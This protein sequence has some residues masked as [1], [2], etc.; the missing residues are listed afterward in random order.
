M[1]HGWGLPTS[2]LN[3]E[4]RPKQAYLPLQTACMPALNCLMKMPYKGLCKTGACL[5]TFLLPYWRTAG[6]LLFL[7]PVAGWGQEAEAWEEEAACLEM[8]LLRTAGLAGT[9]QDCL[10]QFFPSQ[11]AVPMGQA[12][13]NTLTCPAV[14]GGTD[15][16]S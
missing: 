12:C 4:G 11:L 9:S 8:C 7:I 2:C 16:F 5:G 3:T 14:L 15:I 1:Q 13:S 6:R 10:C